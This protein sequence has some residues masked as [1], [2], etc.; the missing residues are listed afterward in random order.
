MLLKVNQSLLM[1]N[2]I[3]NIFIHKRHLK[4]KAK[5]TKGWTKAK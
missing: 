2:L 1:S 3:K 5:A 4:D